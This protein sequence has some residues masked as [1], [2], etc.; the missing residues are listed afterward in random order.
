MQ[1]Q[2]AR[3]VRWGGCGN[4]HPERDATRRVLTQSLAERKEA[5]RMAGKSISY[6]EQKRDLPEIKAVWRPEY[7]DIH[8]QVLQDVLLR[9]DKAFKAFFRRIQN[10][11]T[12][13]Y[14]RFQGRNRYNSFTY[15]QGG[16]SLSEKHITLSKIGPMQFNLD[17]PIE[18]KIKTC[19]IK[20]EAGQWFAMFSC[21][22][23]PPLPLPASQEEVGI[24][25]GLL[26]FAALSE[27]S[28]IDNP[29]YYRKAEKTLVWRQQSLDRKKKRSHRREKARKLLAK[30]HRRI[31]NQCRDFLHKQSRRLMNR[32]QT[33][34]FEDLE[35][36]NLVKRPKPKQDEKGNYLANGASGKVGLNKSISDAGWGMFVDM[37]SFKA[38]CAGRT[39]VKVNPYKTSQI[40]SACLKECP[41]KGLDERTHMLQSDTIKDEHTSIVGSQELGRANLWGRPTPR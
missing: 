14:P 17:R 36:E 30:A 4:V 29:R 24:D 11:E 39:L 7:Q 8:S 3:R 31:R 22:C 6:Y 41:H 37:V 20:Y 10:G 28:F 15:P 12:P 5:Y 13:G 32:Y 35:T 33:I 18:G 9:L 2:L 16:Y 21:E 26:H 27:R 25:L 1:G 19:T 23:E 34:V 40:C 38:E